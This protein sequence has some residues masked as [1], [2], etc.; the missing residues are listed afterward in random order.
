MSRTVRDAK[1]DTRQARLKLTAQPE[2]YW[3]AI[4]EGCHLGYYKGPR[5]GTWIARRRSTHGGYLK[6]RLGTADDIGDAE[7]CAFLSYKQAH[8]AAISWFTQALGPS[9]ATPYTV[10]VALDD[11]L[12][13]YRRR[14]GKALRTTKISVDAF[15]SPQLGSTVI[16]ELTAKIIRDWHSCLAEAA[17]RLRT[18]QGEELQKERTVDSTDPE[19]VRRRR[20]TA[21]RVLT[22]LKAA[23]NHAFREGKVASDD[24][25][26]RVRPFREADAAKIRYLDPGEAQRLV[27]AT[28]P[29]SAR[30]C[31]P[32]F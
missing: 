6:K 19:A 7:G 10:A 11:Y 2:P 15:I 18:R 1:L 23:L 31:K 12:A 14:G 20:A 27:N 32:H 30:S 29:H 17:P 3:R 16:G 26:R 25:W 5:G 4:T 8:N 21:N 22:V 13:D 28:D 9:P 24:A